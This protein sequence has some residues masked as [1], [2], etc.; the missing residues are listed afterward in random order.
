[1][2]LLAAM[3]GGEAKPAK[4]AGRRKIFDLKNEEVAIDWQFEV[5]KYIHPASLRFALLRGWTIRILR[6]L[7]SVAHRGR[8]FG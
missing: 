3:V 7:R 2:L 6:W 5:R 4:L 8:I 1:M